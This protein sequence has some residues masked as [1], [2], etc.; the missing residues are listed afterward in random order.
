MRM[1]MNDD[2]GDRKEKIVGGC[3][4]FLPNNLNSF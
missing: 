3:G 2:V 4:E 1:G